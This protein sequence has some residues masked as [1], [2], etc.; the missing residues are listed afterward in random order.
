MSL[1]DAVVPPQQISLRNVLV[2]TD[3]S[4][5]SS[6]A[7]MYALSLARRY[8]ATLYFAHIVRAHRTESGGV[9]TTVDQAWRDGQHLTTDLLVSGEL[10][11]VPYKLLVGEGEVWDGLSPMVEENSIDLIVTGTR[12]RTGLSKMLFGSVAE[13]IFRQAPCPVITVGPNTPAPSAERHGLERILYATDFTPQSLHAA[14]YAV[15]LAQHYQAHLWLLHV[16]PDDAPKSDA[17]K[18]DARQRLASLTSTPGLLTHSPEVFVGQG[19]PGAQILDFAEQKGGDLI[20]LGVTH[21]GQ[22][23]FFGR[24]WSVA[25]EVAGRAIC[26]V[27]TVRAPSEQ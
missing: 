11:G 6:I 9:L 10:R 23:S 26:P 19:A 2:A 21:P 20:V 12:G 4:A 15:S 17:I 3:F 27:L 18:E 5:G 16:L 1:T 7:V 22:G 25:S 13:R 8:E 24:R 14:S